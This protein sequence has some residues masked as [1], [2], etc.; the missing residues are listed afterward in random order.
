MNGNAAQSLCGIAVEQSPCP[1]DHLGHFRNRLNRTD[2]VAR[3]LY[4]HERGAL[5]NEVDEGTE[6]DDPICANGYQLKDVPVIRQPPARFENTF[7]L[8]RCSQHLPTTCWRA[9]HSAL[10]CE[11]VTLSCTACKN[12]L[13]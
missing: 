13:T 6:V 9:P 1:V 11:V 2:L 4:A 10:D 3:C 8:N 12:D 7:M 5:I